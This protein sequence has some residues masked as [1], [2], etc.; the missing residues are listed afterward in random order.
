MLNVRIATPPPRSQCAAEDHV[1]LYL[2]AEKPGDQG[3]DF[4]AVWRGSLLKKPTPKMV[5]I[6]GGF[7]DGADAFAYFDQLKRLHSTRKIG[8]WYGARSLREMFYDEV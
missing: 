3:D 2:V 4:R 5:F 1:I 6:G 7:R 8:F